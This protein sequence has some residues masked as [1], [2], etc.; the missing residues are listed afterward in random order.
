[1]WTAEELADDVETYVNRSARKWRLVMH[2]E[3]PYGGAKRRLAGGEQ[4]GVLTST[5]GKMVNGEEASAGQ[6][7]L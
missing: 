6:L 3:S 1:L 7:F 5:M 2:E 4:S